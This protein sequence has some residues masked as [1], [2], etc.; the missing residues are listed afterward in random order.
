MGAQPY[1]P[2][3][4]EKYDFDKIFRSLNFWNLHKV[5]QKKANVCF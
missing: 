1:N 5:H 3:K 2:I 4:I